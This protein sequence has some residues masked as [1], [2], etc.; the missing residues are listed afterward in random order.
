MA[1]KGVNGR[2]VGGVWRG[3]A[4]EGC[5]WGMERGGVKKEA[6]ERVSSSEYKWEFHR[7]ANEV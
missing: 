5:G 1:A 6:N 4:C 7:G 2:G 3:C